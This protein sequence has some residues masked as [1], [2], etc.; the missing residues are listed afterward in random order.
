VTKRK[1]VELAPGPLEDHAARFDDLFA[2]RVQRSGLRRYPEGL[3]LP[4]ERNKTLTALANTEPV[5]G[6][7]GL[8]PVGRHIRVSDVNVDEGGHDGAGSNTPLYTR[9]QSRGRSPRPLCHR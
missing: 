1:P 8:T 3:L 7:L 9:V 5:V 6:A 2:S 4:A